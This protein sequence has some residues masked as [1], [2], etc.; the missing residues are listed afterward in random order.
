MTNEKITF[1]HL[2]DHVVSHSWHDSYV[3]CLLI[4]AEHGTEVITS[5]L[6]GSTGSLGMERDM[7]VVNFLNTDSEWLFWTDTDMGFKRDTVRNLMAAGA[8]IV[9]GLYFGQSSFRKDEYGGYELATWP[10]V[11]DYTEDKKAYRPRMEYARDSLI[12]CDGTGSGL[13]LIHRSVFETIA[14]KQGKNEWYAPHPVYR[15]RSEDLSFCTRAQDAGY[16]IHVDTRVKATHH[17]NIWLG[18]QY[19]DPKN[20]VMATGEQ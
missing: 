15:G 10:L 3:N 5:S 1:A 19:Y 6:H 16:D 18:E 11:Y 12:T 8:P 14:G 9:G 20:V 17:K 13:I 4:E 7:A 2:H